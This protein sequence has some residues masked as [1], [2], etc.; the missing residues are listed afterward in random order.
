MNALLAAPLAPRLVVVAIFG[1]LGGTAVH[2]VV[3]RLSRRFGSDAAKRHDEPARMPGRRALSWIPLIGCWL[4]RT[5]REEAAQRAAAR[6]LGIELSG[7]FGAAALYA[8]EVGADGLLADA[9][10]VL[11]PAVALVVH[12]QFAAHALLFFWMMAASLIDIDEKI[13]PDELTVPATLVGLVLAAALPWCLLPD[14]VPPVAPGWWGAVELLDWPFMTLASPAAWPDALGGAPR[15]GSLAIAWL[16]YA[17]WC[18]ALLPR[19]W[20][21]RHG[22][23]RA[24]ALC[25][26]RVARESSSRRIA[27]LAMVGWAV[28]AGAWWLGGRNWQGLLSALVGLGAA[29]GLTWAVRL[30]AGRAMRREA[31]GFGDVTLMAAL[32]TLLGWQACLL[33]FLLAPLAGLVYGVFQLWIARDHEIPYGPFLCLAAAWVVVFWADVWDVAAPRFELGWIVPAMVVGGLALL[34][35]LLA[36]LGALK[37]FVAAARDKRDDTPS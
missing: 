34:G 32:G 28:I 3:E 9:P 35:G 1:A 17:G 12:L 26:A 23:G 5:G 11:P 2:V 29:G 13:I 25:W 20:Y 33:V 6:R 24:V 36:V 7:S 4:A 27:V 14:L 31:L 18:F 10:A 19:T 8:W 22:V 15:F 37:R 16:C 30:I 21:A